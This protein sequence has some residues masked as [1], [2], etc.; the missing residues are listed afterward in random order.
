MILEISFG[1]IGGVNFALEESW[2]LIRNILS[3]YPNA[4]WKKIVDIKRG[5]GKYVVEID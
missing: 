1:L 3:K 2:G 4:T 5:K